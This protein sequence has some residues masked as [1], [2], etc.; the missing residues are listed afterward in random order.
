MSAVPMDEESEIG[1]HSLPK[2]MGSRN[3][4]QAP[5]SL[6]RTRPGREST[7]QG[8]SHPERSPASLT[9]TLPGPVPLTDATA[10][11]GE[12]PLPTGSWHHSQ[13]ESFL[14]HSDW[15]LILKLIRFAK[16]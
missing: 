4:T 2:K 8:P 13:E 10:S 9:R 3:Q 15:N 7:P 16:R 5:L 1:V 11:R 12:T 6:P 14:T